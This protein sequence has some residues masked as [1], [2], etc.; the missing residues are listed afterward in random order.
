MVEDHWSD[1]RRGHPRYEETS[2]E[3]L[4]SRVPISRR[5]ASWF[6]GGNTPRIM[7]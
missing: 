6:L 7:M 4:A 2:P 3:E 1:T 5:R